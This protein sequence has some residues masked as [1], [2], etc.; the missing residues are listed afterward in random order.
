MDIG[1]MWDAFHNDYPEIATPILNRIKREHAAHEAAMKAGYVR[2]FE[3]AMEAIYP[4]WDEVRDSQEFRDWLAADPSRVQR[5]QTPGVRSAV[6]LLNE[7]D[8]AAGR[9]RR[10]RAGGD[11]GMAF[12][13]SLPPAKQPRTPDPFFGFASLADSAPAKMGLRVH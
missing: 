5:A 13:D 12:D 11:E 7:Y 6:K 2:I 9:G 10:L 4:S 3:E 8:K 1:R